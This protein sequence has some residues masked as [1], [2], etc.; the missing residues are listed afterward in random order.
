[1]Y[2]GF[3]DKRGFAIIYSIAILFIE[4]EFC[5]FFQVMENILRQLHACQYACFLYFK[6]RLTFRTGRYGCQ[7]RVIAAAHI[8][9]QCCGNEFLLL[10][11]LCILGRKLSKYYQLNYPDY[12][13]LPEK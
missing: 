5:I 10:S 11:K 7:C 9:E 3:N 2:A 4:G 8:F 13:R 12:P 6:H 1:M